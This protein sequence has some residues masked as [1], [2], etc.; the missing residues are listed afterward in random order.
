MEKTDKK[1]FMTLMAYGGAMLDYTIEGNL[2][3]FK[4][5]FE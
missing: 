2:D 5:V 3:G 1:S 4:K